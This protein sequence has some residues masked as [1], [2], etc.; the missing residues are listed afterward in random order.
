M[1]KS[2]WQKNTISNSQP[3]LED[4]TRVSYK[5]TFTFSCYLHLIFSSKFQ[6]RKPTLCECASRCTHLGLADLSNI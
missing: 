2:H 4:S 6:K 5:S 3:I 1:T